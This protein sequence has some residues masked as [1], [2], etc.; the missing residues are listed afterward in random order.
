MSSIAKAAVVA[1]GC[2]ISACTVVP[3]IPPDWALP[4]KEIL[5]HAACELRAALI[6]LDGRTNPDQF[7][8]RGWKIKVTL[9]PKV[10]ADARPGAGLTRKV[11]SVPGA[12]KFGTWVVGANNGVEADL[13]GQ[14]FS[15]V[16]F[17]FDSETLIKEVELPC[18]QETLSYH[19]L[20]KQLGIREWLYRSADAM[21]LTRSA[22]DAPSFT[23]DVYIKFG[24][25][26]SYTYTFPPGTD[27]ASLGGYFQLQETLTINFT[28]KA[29]VDKFTVISLPRGGFPANIGRGHIPSPVAIVE[30][31]QSQLQQIR[32]QLQ[33]L[34][35]A[36]Q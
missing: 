6:G 8:A 5:L 35:P 26:G 23:A 7:D 24:G 22:I 28:A 16:D 3:D 13:R 15:S 31:Q 27:L 33:N 9:N 17:K 25:S 1:F 21:V 10:E 14:K 34:R 29:K 12:L 20:T 19:S 32:Q 18:D 4:M 2:S 11:P 30:E 36:N